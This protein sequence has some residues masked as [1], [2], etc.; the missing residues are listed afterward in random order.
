MATVTVAAKATRRERWAWYL[1]DFGNSA[2]AAVVL[3]AVYSAYFQ[4]EVVGGAEGSRLWGLSVGIAML[5]VAL[6]SP[7]LGAIADFSGSK[8]RFLLFYTAM[9]CLFTAALF[10]VTRGQ[11]VMGMGLFIL[12]EIGYR[13]AQVFYNGLLP[14]IAA[15]E[16]MG[17]ISG[18]GWAIGTAGGVI[19][20]LLILP[21][22]VLVGGTFVVRLSLVITAIFFALSA[23][24]I[25]LWLPERAQPQPL[26][27]GENYLSIAFRRLLQTIRTAGQFKEFV[28]F[29]IAFLVYNDGIIMALDFAAIIGAVLFGMDQQLLI[30]FMIIVQITNVAGAY[31]FGVLVDRIGGKGSLRVSLLLMIAVVVALYLN[32]TQTGYFVIGAVA[33]VA[34]AGAQSVSRTM[35]AI[36]APPGQSAEFY[37]FFAVIG[38]TSSFIGP[39]VYGWLAAEAALW[40]QGQGQGVVLAEQSGQRLA[41]L[42]IGAFIL[43][44]LLLLTLVDEQRARALAQGRVD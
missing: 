19:C 9:A 18:N 21:L 44:G 11:I 16:E 1:Y 43:V 40:Y 35:V 20:L 23:V 22:I 5:V 15:P 14:E 17:R 26:P 30:V 12:A 3:L 33:G 13:S 39:A 31:I 2:Y 4:G 32:Q 8:K 10:L 27:P 42:S 38:R 37:G 41:I 34:M 28:K 6:T 25:F 7:V 24:P 29:M 36:F